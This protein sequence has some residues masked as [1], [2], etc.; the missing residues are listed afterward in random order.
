MLWF[1]L[2]DNFFIKSKIYELLE[3]K[4]RK[5]LSD[6]SSKKKWK[7]LKNVFDFKL[8]RLTDDKHLKEAI[9]KY[10]ISKISSPDLSKAICLIRD[11][12]YLSGKSL[13]ESKKI[14]ESFLKEA[15]NN[16]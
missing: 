14:V 12:K 9:L 8:V 10:A 15:E 4:S 2:N 11:Y 6:I 16:Q 13:Q 1:E 5:K 3:Q 7:G